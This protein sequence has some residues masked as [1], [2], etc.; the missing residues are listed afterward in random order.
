MTGVI[1]VLWIGFVTLVMELGRALLKLIR[2]IRRAWISHDVKGGR[3][4]IAGI[5][6]PLLTAAMA[7]AWI[8]IIGTLGD[9][10]RSGTGLFGGAGVN[11]FW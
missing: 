9:Y 2:F 10:F 8:F 7:A 3:E 6:V 11:I 5:A 1:F 4:A